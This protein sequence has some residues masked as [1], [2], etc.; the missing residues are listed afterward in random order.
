MSDSLQDPEKPDW[1]TEL[2]QKSWEPEILLSGIVLYGMFQAPGLL[3]QFYSFAQEN[4]YGN[5]SDLDNLVSILK[6]AFYWLTCGLILH[7]VSRGIWVGMVGLSFTFPNG[8]NKDKLKLAE[9]FANRIERIPSIEKIII[10]LEKICSSLFSISFMLFMMMIGAYLFFLITL[11]IPILGIVFLFDIKDFTGVLEKVLIIYVFTFLGIGLISLIDF[12]TLGFLKRIKWL[13]KIY[14]PIHLLVSSITLARFY[15][16]VYYTI[17]TNFNRWKIAGFLI[18]FVV[19]TFFGLDKVEQSGIPGEE[20]TRIE[21]WSNS[22]NV[23]NF[24]GYYDD[25]ND[26]FHSVQAQIQSDIISE[27][28]VR[29]FVVLKIGLEDSIMKNCN[30]DSLI[31]LDT[32]S[33]FMKLHCLKEFYQVKLDDEKL[34]NINWLFHY[35]QKTRQRGIMTYIDITN[36]E[37][38]MHDIRVKGPDGMYRSNFAQIPFYRELSQSGYLVPKK[39]EEEEKESYLKLKGVLPK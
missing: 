21:L 34:E 39:P 10:N 36:L 26:D 6:I 19:L 12:L 11:V 30:Y 37:Q 31:K 25:Q 27:N 32:G 23:A 33:R 16:P 14:Y 2:Q 35:K 22:Q 1:L 20:I 3:D 28:T 4:L 29:L 15:R 17:I 38:G 13:S 8:I 9:P 18:F 7:L 24:S 5:E